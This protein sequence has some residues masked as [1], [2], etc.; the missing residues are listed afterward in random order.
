MAEEAAAAALASPT[1]ERARREL[2]GRLR[3]ALPEL[4]LLEEGSTV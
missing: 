4:G 1:A 2:H 3:T